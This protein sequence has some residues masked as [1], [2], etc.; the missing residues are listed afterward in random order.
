MR[1]P[2]LFPEVGGGKVS[3][4]V[5]EEKFWEALYEISNKEKKRLRE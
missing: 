4:D 5:W 3:C 1:G 2:A